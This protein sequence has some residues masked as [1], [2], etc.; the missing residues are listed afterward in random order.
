M[1]PVAVDC[2]KNA[3]HKKT[4]NIYHVII[5]DAIDCTNERDGTHVVVY[6]RDGMFFVREKIEFEQKFDR[7]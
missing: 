3:V 5:E 4:G 2:N 7:S 1:F 6:Y